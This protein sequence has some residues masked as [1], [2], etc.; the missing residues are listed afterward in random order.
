MRT[1]YSAGETGYETLDEWMRGVD[2]PVAGALLKMWSRTRIEPRT[3]CPGEAG[4]TELVRR[5]LPGRAPATEELRTHIV[6]FCADPSARTLI[7]R[8]SVG[9]GKSTI[10]R[11]IGFGKRIA[12]LRER[13]AR[14]LI[15]D[16]R[17]EQPGRIDTRSMPWYVEFTATGLVDELACAQLYGIKRGAASGVEAS[18]GVFE[19]A[20]M[21]SGGEPWDGATVTGGVV[22]LDEIGDLSPFLQAKLLPVLS[23]GKYYLVGGEGDPHHVRSFDGIVVSATWH[24]LDAVHM[25]KDLLSRLAGHVIDVP[26]LR[27]RLDDFTEIVASVYG[28]LLTRYRERLSAMALDGDFDRSFW[29][30][31]VARVRPPTDE[32]MSQLRAVDWAR[33]GDMRGLITA[34]ERIVL[35]REA[36]DTVIRQLQSVDSATTDS[37]DDANR[38]LSRVLARPANGEGVIRHVGAVQLTERRALRQLLAADAGARAQVAR[39]LRIP[40]SRLMDDLRQ[41][42]RSRRRL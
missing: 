5:V 9:A 41:L 22:F 21:D 13:A 11:L 4:L 24:P 8:G 39:Q 26:P 16:L 12:P 42:D 2:V 25:R 30:A 36:A 3:S 35:A 14:E 7:L 20:Q 19:R 1:C 15:A 29:E 28:F 23:G 18:P 17:F 37:I 34:L 31:D 10:A 27:E 38:L 6:R 32:E 40:E 33:H